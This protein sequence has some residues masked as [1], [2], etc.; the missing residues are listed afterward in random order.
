MTTGEWP[1]WDSLNRNSWRP[2]Q[3][4]NWLGA[5]KSNYFGGLSTDIVAGDDTFGTLWTLDP[6]RGYDDAP[7]STQDPQMFE[8]VVTGGLPMRTRRTTRNDA[9]FLN[10]NTG[11]PEFTNAFIT[12]RTSDDSGNTWTNQG[13]IEVIPGEYDQE[14][15][16][17]SLGL[18]KSPGRIFEF[19]DY[20]ATIRIDDATA[21]IEGQDE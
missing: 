11:A 2:H 21:I 5:D 19:T 9:V 15:M 17:R 3:G 12:L 6:N 8:R 16:W 20:G 4:L 18:V 13:A 14:V 10:I 7:K 1:K